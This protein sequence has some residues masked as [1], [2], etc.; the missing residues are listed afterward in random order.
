VKEKY[1]LW[2]KAYVA[3]HHG[4][5]VGLCGYACNEMKA[6]FPEL[7]IVKGFYNGEHIWLVDEDNEIVDPTVSQFAFPDEYKPL[8]PG[9]SI[10]VGR[11]MYCGMYINAVVTD[12]AP[13]PPEIDNS[14]FYDHTLCS[15]DCA[16]DYAA[17]T[18][19][20]AEKTS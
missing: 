20:T 19:V 17:Y 14:S 5:V 18:G 1:R 3:R 7:T 9:D 12:P 15:E 6:A 13:E 8:V 16:T 10:R 11:C 4:R 2:I